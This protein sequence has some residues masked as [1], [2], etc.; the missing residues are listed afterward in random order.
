MLPDLTI[1]VTG[2][3]ELRQGQSYDGLVKLQV[4]NKG[5]PSVPGNT[6]GTE[7]YLIDLE[8]VQGDTRIPLTQITATPSV[9]GGQT[10]ELTP[11][12][13]I[14]SS[15]PPGDYCLTAVIDPTNRVTEANE[16]NNSHCVNITIRR[17]L[18]IPIDPLPID[19]GIIVLKPDL[20]VS[21]S[22]PAEVVR[23][24]SL[25]GLATVKVTNGG[26]LKAAGNRPGQEGY[27]LAFVLSTSTEIP[28]AYGEE[29][30]SFRDGAVLPRG[31]ITATSDLEPGTSVEYP[32]KGTIPAD[33]PPGLYCLG[34]VVDPAGRVSEASEENNTACLM[35]TVRPSDRTLPIPDPEPPIADP[36]DPAPPP[37]DRG[38]P[39]PPPD[40]PGDP[41]DP[42][43]EPP[44]D[45]EPPAFP[46]TCTD[47]DFSDLPA[48]H[49]A[50]AAV[51]VLVAEGII[52]GYEDGTFR[53]ER[54]VT[55]AEFAKMYTLAVGI[56]PRPGEPLPFSDTAGHWAD[57]MGF[58]AAAVANG[59]IIGFPD[60]TFRPDDLVTRAQGVKIVTADL[61]AAYGRTVGS[62]PVD[63]TADLW[64]YAYVAVGIDA[65]LM[66]AG[67]HYP[68][69]ASAA[70]AGDTP[71]TR[72]EAAM[73]L[74]NLLVLRDR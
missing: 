14:P 18:L 29:S 65:G 40:D 10:V 30:A 32:V 19:P 37:G 63:V 45:S 11:A 9:N 25:E 20:T 51:S 62:L 42:S 1:T 57:T 53:P 26:A 41:T 67:A 48:S 3:E 24:T 73:L 2:P 35:V 13:A 23:G 4:S 49:P 28:V 5:L 47:Q 69:F 39:T 12:G 43:P 50:C 59:A 58:L 61:V 68:V 8:L 74:A 7:S 72:A 71:M 60:G 54:S 70:F 56:D 46:T 17:F 55:R 16:D 38:D 64:Y 31:R 66:G 33:T 15:T 21:L 27:E 22:G 44:G 34:V 52:N 6:E 36:G